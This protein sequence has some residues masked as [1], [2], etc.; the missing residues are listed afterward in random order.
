MGTI[1]IQPKRPKKRG[2]AARPFYWRWTGKAILG[3]I[4]LLEAVF[5][6]LSGW[7]KLPNGNY[8]ILQKNGTDVVCLEYSRRGA[9]VE[10]MK[11]ARGESNLIH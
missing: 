1:F 9:V 8:Q 5:L 11:W 6:K 10:M 7:R 3:G 2:L 4:Y